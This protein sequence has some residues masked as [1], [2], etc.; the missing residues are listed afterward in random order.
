MNVNLRVS[1]IED[2]V[3]GLDWVLDGV[4]N[5]LAIGMSPSEQFF[6]VDNG[7]V[8]FT[9]EVLPSVWLVIS[10][11]QTGGMDDFSLYCA[12]CNPAGGPDGLLFE[13]AL[14]STSAPSHQQVQGILGTV[15]D[16]YSYSGITATVYSG[17][18]PEPSS[19]EVLSVGFGLMAALL[20]FTRLRTGRKEHRDS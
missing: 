20:C 9:P 6:T 12:V 13:F 8:T 7:Q 3:F 14:P 11:D 2:A 19:L 5:A 15:V 16:V 18:L 10:P 4:S 1:P 17:N